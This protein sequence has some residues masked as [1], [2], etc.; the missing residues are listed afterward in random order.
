MQNPKFTRAKDF[1]GRSDVETDLCWQVTCLN[2]QLLQT[3][4]N[5][6]VGPYWQAKHFKCGKNALSLWNILHTLAALQVLSDDMIQR[7]MRSGLIIF[8]PSRKLFAQFVPRHSQAI[9]KPNMPLSIRQ[10]HININKLILYKS[11]KCMGPVL[12]RGSCHTESC[13]C[14]VCFV[15]NICIC[16]L[17]YSWV[18]TF[19]PPFVCACLFNASL[20][21]FCASFTNFMCYFFLTFSHSFTYSLIQAFVHFLS[22]PEKYGLQGTS[23][24]LSFKY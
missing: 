23:K 9:A 15:I 24:I 18:R 21:A 22:P 8:G 19:M 16:S 11:N 4:P 5:V 13:V 17:I 12:G 20:D 1:A 10:T 14:V 2:S 7:R 3:K 6:I